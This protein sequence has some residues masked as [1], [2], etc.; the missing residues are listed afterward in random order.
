[1]YARLWTLSTLHKNPRRIG[2]GLRIMLGHELRRIPIPR[3]RVNKG[4]EKGRGC[5]KPRP[6]CLLTA[7]SAVV[8]TTHTRLRVRRTPWNRC[9]GHVR[10][11]E[12]QAPALL[13]ACVAFGCYWPPPPCSSPSPC[14]PPSSSSSSPPPPPVSPPV[15]PP[16]VSVACLAAPPATSPA[17]S[18]TCPT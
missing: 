12:A 14:W 2:T 7:L 13:A 11:A 17:W 1:M 10:R 9:A 6:V 4:M 5:S 3:T 15:R 16:T 18:V 8:G